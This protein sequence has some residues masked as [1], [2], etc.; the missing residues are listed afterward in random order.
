MGFLVLLARYS[1]LGQL[2]S[3]PVGFGNVGALTPERLVEAG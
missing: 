2:R 3:E 1:G